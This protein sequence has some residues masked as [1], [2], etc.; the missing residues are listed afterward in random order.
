[1]LSLSISCI[2]KPHVGDTKS[3]WEWDTKLKDESSLIIFGIQ[4]GFNL[5]ICYMANFFSTYRN[6]PLSGK[7]R[8]QNDKT[9]QNN[10]HWFQ[11]GTSI[12][13]T[14]HAYSCRHGYFALSI[15]AYSIQYM[16]QTIKLK[17]PWQEFLL[18][19][20][21]MPLK[22]QELLIQKNLHHLPLMMTLYQASGDNCQNFLDH[23][24]KMCRNCRNFLE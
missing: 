20:I 24:L 17:I 18:Q 11:D 5:L 9:S 3:E 12:Y 21:Q 19:V 1:M 6:E 4:F 7:I 13:L 10:H 8:N 2:I 14:Y 23:F 22:C 15:Q 16:S